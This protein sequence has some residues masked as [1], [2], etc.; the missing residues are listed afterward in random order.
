MAN[1]TPAEHI[2]Q[3]VAIMES[4][5][6]LDEIGSIG[7]TIGAAAMGAMAAMSGGAKAQ[8]AATPTTQQAATQQ[9]QP[10]MVDALMKDLATWAQGLRGWDANLSKGLISRA[11]ESWNRAR[12]SQH[13][14]DLAKTLEQ[15]NRTSGKIATARRLLDRL[16]QGGSLS[17][18]EIDQLLAAATEIGA[19]AR[20]AV[21][22]LGPM[23]RVRFR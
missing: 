8:P 20:E 21:N 16:D 18:E 23:S 22:M 13:A 12:T 3:M 4:T 5:E 1:T 7:R 2:R 17:T 11:Q 10:E 14:E 9:I 19:A 15:L 6:T